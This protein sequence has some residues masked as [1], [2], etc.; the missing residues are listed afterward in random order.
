[1][2]EWSMN[3]QSVASG[4]NASPDRGMPGNGVDGHATTAADLAALDSM[5]TALSS[6]GMNQV[7]LVQVDMHRSFSCTGARLSSAF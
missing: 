6:F 1:M 3:G 5:Y 4:P 2:A 7:R